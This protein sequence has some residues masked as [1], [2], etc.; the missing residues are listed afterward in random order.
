M[1]VTDFLMEHFDKIMDYHFTAEIEKE[2]DEIAEGDLEWVK[3]IR[4]FI[5]HFTRL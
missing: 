3:M 2:F 1:L 4:A 5:I